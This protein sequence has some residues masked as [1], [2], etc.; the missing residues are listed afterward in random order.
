MLR[1]KVMFL[2][3]IIVLSMFLFIHPIKADTE[4]VPIYTEEDVSITAMWD[5]D[6]IFLH[7]HNYWE[8]NLYL[9][10]SLYPGGELRTKSITF[11]KF[12]I[13][14]KTLGEN[15][16]IT[17]MKVRLTQ[18]ATHVGR[19]CLLKTELVENNWVSENMTWD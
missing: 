11:L 2:L 1:K 17:S 14:N 9:G 19:T 5:E 15:E 4:I 6:G 12:N 18:T 3:G 7:Y 13:P 16:F 8:N 10:G